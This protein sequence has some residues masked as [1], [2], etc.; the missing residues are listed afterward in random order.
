MLLFIEKDS[1][2]PVPVVA[3]Q[4]ISCYSL[5]KVFHV[6]ESELI[7]F[8]TSHVTLYPFFPVIT[9]SL[10]FVSIHLML[11]FINYWGWYSQKERVSIHLM[12]LFI[13]DAIFPIVLST[14]VSI[15]LMLLFIF[16]IGHLNSVLITGFNTS[17]VTLYRKEVYDIDKTIVFQYISCYSLSFD[18]ITD[19][20]QLAQ[21]QYISCYS[22]SSQCRDFRILH[23]VSIHLMLLFIGKAF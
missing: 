16:I 3:F 22:L 15:H 4:Y 12:L 2:A 21:F 8:N 18:A 6:L 11:L 13:P 7:R 10:D 9:F 14:F 1:L 17:H 5:S 23:Q 19:Y 20:P